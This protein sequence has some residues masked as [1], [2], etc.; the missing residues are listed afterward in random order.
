MEE[1]RCP[2]C[3]AS[4]EPALPLCVACGRL[5]PE[6]EA[7][8]RALV[9]RH[10]PEDRRASTEISQLLAAASGQDEAR[11]E[12]Y[13]RRGP[14]LFRLPASAEVAERLRDHLMEAGADVELA[15]AVSDESRWAAWARGLWR[16][17][18]VGVLL[19]GG[20]GLATLWVARGARTFLLWL[21]VSGALALVDLRGF[22]RR[23]TLS[24]G[25]LA[26]RLGLVSGALARPAAALL[27]RARSAS[28]REA[29]GTVLIEHARL[30]GSVGR[31]LAGHPALQAPFRETLD[32]LGE[33]T[34][35]IAENAV[36]IEEAGDGDPPDLPERLASLRALGSAETDRQLKNLLTSRDQRAAR[37][38]WLLQAH[39]LLLVRLEAIAER[40]RG[41]RQETA[42]RALK[43]TADPGA[44]DRSLE[45]LGREL[46][47]ASSALHEVERGLPQALPE[48]IAEV[49]APR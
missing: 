39:A 10:L 45:A 46:E 47:L 14:A 44:A 40:L 1:A 30:L 12:R 7:E 48:V 49:I 20:A 19:W 28:L 35:R 37:H 34:L 31:A 5:F 4:L 42:S 25:L 24:A 6:Q 21:L 33:H 38:Q 26:R 16:E 3:R 22:A 2:S 43:L 13:L 41:L 9:V 32:E 27:R 29:L 18:Q 15:D 23:I 17:Q 11:V 8:A 36:A